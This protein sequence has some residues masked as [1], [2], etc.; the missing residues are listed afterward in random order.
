MTEAI[1]VTEEELQQTITLRQRFAELTQKYGQLAFTHRMIEQEKAELETQFDQLN[2]FQE[3][4][5]RGLN[6][7]YGIGTLDVE[8]GAF[9]SEKE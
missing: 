4:F 1:K 7:K 8:T 3:K 2:D 9:T 6:A 5:I